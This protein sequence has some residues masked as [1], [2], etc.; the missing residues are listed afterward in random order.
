MCTVVFDFSYEYCGPCKDWSINVAG[1]LF[2][3]P[4]YFYPSPWFYF[5]VDGQSNTDIN[6]AWNIINAQLLSTEHLDL[7]GKKY[8]FTSQLKK[9][10]YVELKSYAIGIVKSRK[11]YIQ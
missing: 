7:L 2:G 9:G 3:A 8:Q 5:N 1:E 4:A 6:D 10:V 11:M